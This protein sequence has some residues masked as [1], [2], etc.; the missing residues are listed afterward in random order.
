MPP[1]PKAASSVCI[2]FIS[3]SPE[4]L[5]SKPTPEISFFVSFLEALSPGLAS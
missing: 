5:P 2:S 1:L 4:E 3:L